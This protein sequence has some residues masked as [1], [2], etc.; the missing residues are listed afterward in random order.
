MKI[1]KKIIKYFLILMTS[2]L[3]IVAVADAA[4]IYLP[5]F[6]AQ[7]QIAEVGQYAQKV[8]E[9]DIPDHVKIIGLGEA[10]HG[11]LEFQELKLSVFQGLVEKE[12]VRAFALEMDFSEGMIINNYIHT[13]EG[14]AKEIVKNLSFTIYHTQQMQDLIEW[15]KDYNDSKPSSEQLS[16]YGFDMQNPELG[17]DLILEY[18]RKQNILVDENLQTVLE[19]IKGTS[20]KLSDAEKEKAI[21]ILKQIQSIIDSHQKTSEGQ[22][23]GRAITNILHSFDYYKMSMADYTGMSNARDGYMADNVAWIQMFEE[24]RGHE[25]IMIAGH[26]GH[27]A[28][29]SKNFMC[30]GS[31]L[32]EKFQN[33][34]FVI[35][36]DYFQTTVNINDIGKAEVGR[37]N[38]SFNSADPLAAQAK[39]VGGSYY[40]NFSTVEKGGET[41]KII[42]QPMSMGSLGEGYSF[43]MHFLPTS[44]RIQESPKELYD[45][46]IFV[47]KATPIQPFTD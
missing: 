7:Q 30:M 22:L 42:S 17:I 38:Q 34:Y 1:V 3:A 21:D 41:D 12:K 19:P 29:Q 32:R 44:H 9:I 11:N 45:A 5:Q 47:Y 28:Y 25:R 27:V 8:S 18:C 46:M 4:W 15:M 6:M 36:T 24:E 10:S 26:N 35:G 39:R 31:H 2:L 13:G 33:Q 20:K 23:I 16:F 40:L 37:T 43:M 14:N